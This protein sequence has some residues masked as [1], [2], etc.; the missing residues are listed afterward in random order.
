MRAQTEQKPEEKKKDIKQLVKEAKQMA[1]QYNSKSL[2]QTSN[3]Y[4]N[5]IEKVSME[6]K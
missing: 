2:V 3:K 1:S 6:I 4:D 5:E